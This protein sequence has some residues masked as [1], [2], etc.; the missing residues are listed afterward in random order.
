MFYLCCQ[1][2]ELSISNSTTFSQ[3][4]S[5]L[6][7]QAHYMVFLKARYI[8]LQ[9]IMKKFRFRGDRCLAKPFEPF[10]SGVLNVAQVVWF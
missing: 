2:Y 10:G 7:F 8:L 4:E 6:V 3:A 1:T 9:E 5:R